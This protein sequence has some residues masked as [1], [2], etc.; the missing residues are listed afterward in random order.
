MA[1]FSNVLNLDEFEYVSCEENAENGDYLFHVKPKN[2]NIECPNCE[3][4]N[5]VSYGSYNRMVR[6]LNYTGHKVGISIMGNRRKC[7]DCSVTFVD[8]F[9]S[10]DTNSKMTK[11]LRKEIQ[12]ESLKRPFLQVAQNYGLNVSTVKRSFDDYAA[13]EEKKRVMYSPEVLGIDEAHLNKTMRGVIVDVKEHRVIEILPTRSKVEVMKYFDSLPNSENIKVVTM[14]MWR[15]YR[16]AVYECLLNAC[17]VIDRFHVIKLV[18]EALDTI[19]KRE[20]RRI[21]Q[22]EDHIDLSNFRTLLLSNFEDLTEEQEYELIDYFIESPLIEDAHT[23]KE[24][25]RAIYFAESRREAET[26]FESWAK[27]I[28]DSLPEFQAVISTV[29]NW[30]TEIFNYFDYRYTNGIVECLN[31]TIKS[32]ER[33]GRGFSY[34]VLRAKVLFANAAAKPAKYSYKKPTP[35]TSNMGS[36]GYAAPMI[37]SAESR[38]LICGSGVDLFELSELLESNQL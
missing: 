12:I 4:T 13:A 38:K 10:I 5:T 15:P 29:R 25:F 17:V 9:D 26:S 1:D 8:T 3:S 18:T 2:A 30:H 6:D 11:R 7:K 28:P 24:G 31:N 16:E 37:P 20:A 22:K 27:T 19:R 32:V 35:R 33:L 34:E 36:F 23:L 14:D 21:K